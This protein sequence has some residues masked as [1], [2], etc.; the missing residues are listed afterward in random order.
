[1]QVSSFFRDV[2]FAFSLGDVAFSAAASKRRRIRSVG[3]AGV[4]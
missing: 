4:L 3:G 1:M 2:S